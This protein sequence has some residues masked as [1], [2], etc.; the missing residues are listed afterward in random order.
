MDK[1]EYCN[2]ADCEGIEGCTCGQFSK[3]ASVTCSI[4]MP[5][6]VTGGMAIIV[7]QR[8]GMCGGCKWHPDVCVHCQKDYLPGN[9]D[10]DDEQ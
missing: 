4:A 6:E 7:G 10:D 5:V 8:F 1:K 2:D 3:S 9:L